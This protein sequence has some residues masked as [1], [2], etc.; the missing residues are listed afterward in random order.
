[1]DE[2][3]TVLRGATGEV[4]VR[5]PTV[6]QGYDDDPIAHEDAFTRDWFR[7]GDVGFLDADGYLFVTGCLMGGETRQRRRGA[8]PCPIGVYG[9]SWRLC[10]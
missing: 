8:A 4:V 10:L 6:M 3:G 1:M 5:G 9:L 7:T 2:A